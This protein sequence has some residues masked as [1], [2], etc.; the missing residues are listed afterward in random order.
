MTPS[1]RKRAEL[2]RERI[3]REA[4]RLTLKRRAAKHVM[5]LWNA[6]L[7][8]GWRTIFYPTIGTALGTDCHWLHVVCPACHQLGE[9]D[10]R[11]IDIHPHASIGVVVRAMSCKRCSPPAVCSP[12]WSNAPVMGGQEPVEAQGDNRAH[13]CG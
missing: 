2:E 7:A 9:T 1:A 5:A 6:A 11:T 13:R 3:K 10:L 8:A 12:S 4:E